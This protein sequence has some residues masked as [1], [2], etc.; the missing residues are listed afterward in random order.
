MSTISPSMARL[1]LGAQVCLSLSIQGFQE[2][3]SGEISWHRQRGRPVPARRGEEVGANCCF[4]SYSKLTS[5][6]ALSYGLPLDCVSSRTQEF[7]TP[8]SQFLLITVYHITIIYLITKQ[9]NYMPYI[10]TPPPSLV[11]RSGFNQ[12]GGWVE[13]GGP[14]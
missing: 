12:R 5:T 3:H 10:T 11:P 9:F 13:P 8:R 4:V 6:V 14:G 7:A 1:Y 2:L